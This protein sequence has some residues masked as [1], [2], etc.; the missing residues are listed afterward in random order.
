[1]DILR[2]PIWQSIG[3]FVALLTGLVPAVAWYIRRLSATSEKSQH[4]AIIAELKRHQAQ[5]VGFNAK[6]K[7]RKTDGILLANISSDFLNQFPIPMGVMAVHLDLLYTPENFG[8]PDWI[9]VFRRLAMEG[10]FV[11]VD[12]SSPKRLKI[13]TLVNPGPKLEHWLQDAAELKSRIAGL[14]REG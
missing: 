12:G 11:P 9:V 5:R 4:D 7:K 6:H 14:S 8:A 13:D 10:C 1:M 3:V 2:D